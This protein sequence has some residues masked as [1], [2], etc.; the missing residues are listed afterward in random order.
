MCKERMAHKKYLQ[1]H[2]RELSKTDKGHQTTGPSSPTNPKRT[3]KKIYTLGHIIVKL[4]E[5]KD[6]K[7]NLQAA[8]PSPHQI[9]P[10]KKK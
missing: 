5:V 9:L 8:K 4:S 6:E 3:N 10:W 2:D 7:K 1:R